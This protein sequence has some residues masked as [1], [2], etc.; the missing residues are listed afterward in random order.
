[1]RPKCKK[2]AVAVAFLSSAWLTSCAQM[3]DQAATP[4]SSSTPTYSASVIS[5]NKT[6]EPDKEMTR[7]DVVLRTPNGSAISAYCEGNLLQGL[8]MPAS[9][10]CAIPA[11]GPGYTFWYKN[12]GE[13][14][15]Q[16]NDSSGQNKT[17]LFIVTGTS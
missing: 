7:V 4:P 17:S 1:M 9:E 14:Y 6:P 10:E 12:G 8:V 2:W 11:V 15:L 13:I 3:M 5:V 16:G